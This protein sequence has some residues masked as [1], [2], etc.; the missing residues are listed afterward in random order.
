VSADRDYFERNDVDDVTFPDNCPD[1]V[2]TLSEGELLIGRRS[3]RRGVR[4][5]IDLSGAPEDPG[6][7]HAHALLRRQADGSYAVV[8]PGST[9]GTTLN[10]GTAPLPQNVVTPLKDGDT[11][12]LGAWTRILFHAP[13][14]HPPP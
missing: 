14:P 2:F 11:L 3:E 12:Y 10:E 4:P 5:Q 9:N 7:S 1:R 13:A 6:V 8:D